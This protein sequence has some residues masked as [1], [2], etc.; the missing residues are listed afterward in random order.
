QGFQERVRI[1][2]FKP[3]FVVADLG[4]GRGDKRDSGETPPSGRKT[5]CGPRRGIAL[6]RRGRRFGAGPR[7]RLRSC[8]ADR[9][10]SYSALKTLVRAM[11]QSVPERALI[12]RQEKPHTRANVCRRSPE[13]PN[14]ALA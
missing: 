11:A 8:P 13:R 4:R 6:D 10:S 14:P 3:R 12:V 7:G 1:G 2:V 5:I 9:W